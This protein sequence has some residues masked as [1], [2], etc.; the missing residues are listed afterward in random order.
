MA[1]FYGWPSPWSQGS[2]QWIIPV[3]WRVVGTTD[4]IGTLPHSRT[5]TME[6]LDSFGTSSVSKL[7]QIATPRMP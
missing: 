2:F 5:Q 1:A 4:Y 6:I 3:Q 7:G